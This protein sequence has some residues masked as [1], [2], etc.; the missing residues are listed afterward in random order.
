[1]YSNQTFTLVI[2]EIRPACVVAS[3]FSVVV[4]C[5]SVTLSGP[6]LVI[7]FVQFIIFTTLLVAREILPEKK[8]HQNSVN[9]EQVRSITQLYSFGL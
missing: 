3:L 6:E 2:F 1:M 8:L 4:F 9:V 7:L 5:F